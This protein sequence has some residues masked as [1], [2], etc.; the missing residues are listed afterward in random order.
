MK[1]HL[2]DNLYH[3][4]SQSVTIESKFKENLEKSI[5]SNIDVINSPE[6]NLELKKSCS[7]VSSGSIESLMNV[8]HD[9]SNVSSIKVSDD[10]ETS[11][12]S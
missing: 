5:S 7:S 10:I 1:I 3:L 12:S 6:N 2:S 4:P 11:L 8:V 9:P